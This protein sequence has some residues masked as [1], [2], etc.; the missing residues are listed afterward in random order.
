M[1]T[2]ASCDSQALIAPPGQC[3]VHVANALSTW[4]M[5]CP[6]GHALLGGVQFGTSTITFM[7]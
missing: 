6:C 7:L 2:Q 1:M 3:P 5:P 4:P